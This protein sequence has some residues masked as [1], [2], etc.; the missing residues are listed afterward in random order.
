MEN[1]GIMALPGAG[2]MPDDSAQMPS[3]VSS[4]DAYDAASTAASMVNPQALAALKESVRQNLADLQLSPSELNT[5]IEIFEYMTQRPDQYRQLVDE[6]VRQGILDEG[7]MPE[8]YDPMIIGSILVALNE[9]RMMQ[10]E[11]A[12]SV[13]EQGPPVAGP[14]PMAMAQGGLADMAQYL[15]AQGR[16]GDTMLAHITP[17]EAQLLKDRGG[18]GTINPVTG[19]P[20]FFKKLFKAVGNV[21][22]GVVNAVKS[23]VKGV[24]NVV[25]DVLKTPVGRILGTIALAT[26][27]GP[28][29]IGATLGTAGT[30]ALS[31]GTVTLAG[32]GTLKEALVSGAMGY[33]GGGGDFGG[34]GSPLKAVGSMLPGAAGSALNTGL[35]T[36]VLG[37]GAGLVMGMK[38]REALKMGATAGLVSGG[39][40][41]LSGPTAQAAQQPGAQPPAEMVSP[42]L[43]A[44]FQGGTG[45]AGTAY[46][47]LSMPM[48]EAGG[49][50]PIGTAASQLYAQGDMGMGATSPGGTSPLSMSGVP[51]YASMDYGG[52]LAPVAA[53]PGGLT[54]PMAEAAQTPQLQDRGFFGRMAQGATDLYN[55]YLS[56]SR[57]GLPADAGLIRKYA[58]L[59]AAGTAVAAATGAMKSKPS[60]PNP[61]FDRQRTGRDYINENLDRFRG[62]LDMPV[63][64]APSTVETPTYARAPVGGIPVVLPPGISQQSAGVAQPYNVSGLYGIPLLYGEPQ[65]RAKGGEMRMEEF[66]RKTG[67]INGPGTGTSD[68]IPAMLSDGEFVFTAKAVRNAGGG[69]RRKGAARMYRLMKKLE[70]G[71]VKGK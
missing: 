36:G 18:S 5:V 48:S 58:P 9:M 29:A 69:S 22:K 37:T 63:V 61:L 64:R 25:K 42:P 53:G 59:A 55:E 67:P 35:T 44:G 47:M 17:E 57:P 70:G 66:P 27:L 4:A 46:D 60:D 40:Q 32:G 30:A 54:M 7:D 2:A 51:D 8:E 34:L 50:S 62:G 24:V 71:Q 65:G 6:L 39:L 41:A 16:N 28:T 20:E 31:A 45:Q 52:S 49:I 10:T 1:E 12:A 13:M 21:A 56:P 23:V 38:P 33:I 43:P 26:V 3:M 19:L 11:G 15:A 68:S 14:V